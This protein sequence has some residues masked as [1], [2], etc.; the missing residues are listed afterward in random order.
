VLW[1]DEIEKALATDANDDGVSRRVL[2]YLL[3]WMAERKSSVFVVAT[4]NDV[5]ALPAELLRKGRFDELWFVDLPIHDER[6]AILGTAL[7]AHGR[8]G[9]DVDPHEVAMATVDFTGSEIA[10]L[11]PTALYSAYADG[12]R[13]ITTQ[14]LLAAARDIVP[15]SKT[16]GEKLERLREWGKTRAR[17][18]T[19]PPGQTATGTSAGR[20]LD[21]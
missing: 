13:E 3:T 17:P 9:A 6:V 8:G 4:A 16:M 11:V 2:G 14:D 15:L 12:A 7:K 18:A 20:V 10:E 21:F 1:I 5:T 19:T